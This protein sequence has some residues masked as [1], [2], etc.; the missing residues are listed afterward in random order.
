MQIKTTV[1]YVVN[2]I[3]KHD[4]VGDS[5]AT[6]FSEAILAPIVEKRNLK[7]ENNSG[8]VMFISNH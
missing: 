7:A 1:L 3:S 2:V 8:I 5:I 6:D 4:R